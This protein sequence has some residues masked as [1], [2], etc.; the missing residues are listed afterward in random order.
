M[1]LTI[2]D[3]VQSQHCPGG[4]QANMIAGLALRPPGHVLEFGVWQGDSL[5]FIADR[6]DF[7][8]GFDSFDG[9]PEAWVRDRAHPDT[10][11]AGL[12]RTDPARQVW[13]DNCR[14]WPGWFTDTIP[15]F[16]AEVEGPIG[17][18][19]VDSDLYSSART[20]LFGLDD[21]IV[22]GTVIVFDE[23]YAFPG[24]QYPLWEEHEW[25]ALQEWLAECNREVK[26]V[27][28][29]SQYQATVQ[30]TR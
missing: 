1:T 8:H 14:L 3:V 11:P 25:K 13:P 9:L 27:S 15:L 24:H 23:L 10:H 26:A 30:V 12:F 5:R 19:H 6:V 18:L 29:S 20:I 17:L 7:V 28:R 16:K 21:R 2:Q 22:P 4:M